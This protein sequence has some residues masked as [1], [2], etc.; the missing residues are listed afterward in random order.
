MNFT[1]SKNY[2]MNPSECHVL[3]RH[4]AK[5]KVKL[6]GPRSGFHPLL[7][8]GEEGRVDLP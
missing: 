7:K 6:I 3:C 5:M 4:C 1:T 8:K 2:T